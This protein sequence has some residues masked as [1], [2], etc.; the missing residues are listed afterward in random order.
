MTDAYFTNGNIGKMSPTHAF[1][2]ASIDGGTSPYS[3]SSL[4]LNAVFHSTAEAVESYS[5]VTNPTHNAYWLNSDF[6]SI[7]AD[8]MRSPP[9]L[10]ASNA[11]LRVIATHLQNDGAGVCIQNRATTN[12]TV[13][14]TRGMVGLM[15]NS[16]EVR[17]VIAATNAFMT[18]S[19][20][21]TI[22]PT[23][24]T[25]LRLVEVNPPTYRATLA[26][27]DFWLTNGASQNLIFDPP[28][29][30]TNLIAKT[31]NYLVS[32]SCVVTNG[33]ASGNTNCLT[34]WLAGHTTDYTLET[35]TRTVFNVASVNCGGNNW[36]SIN[37]SQVVYLCKGDVIYLRMTANFSG[38][39][40]YG[41]TV[42]AGS[43]QPTMSI[44]YIGP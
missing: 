21:T 44:T 24:S 26:S 7:I 35:A 25:L 19:Y 41:G 29:S 8:P 1:D 33:G 23:N 36:V 6:N 43:W 42:S 4:A 15:G 40:I 31:G 22:G 14:I 27:G 10:V 12:Q 3:R 17:D 30:G 28:L 34:A 13:T 11:L 38:G 32:Y 9:R 20:S 18:A 37:N 2:F 16:Y 39:R 5:L